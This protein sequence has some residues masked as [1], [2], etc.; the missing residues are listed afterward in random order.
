MTFLEIVLS[1]AGAIL[2]GL[3]FYY[4][5]RV[6]GPWGSLWTFLLVLVLAALAAEAWV[7]PSGPVFYNFSWIPTLFVIF[8]FGLILAA[9][10]PA[11]TRRRRENIEPGEEPSSAMALTGF[12]WILVIFL[13]FAFI[14]SYWWVP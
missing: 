1:I 3:L 10:T 2:I 11:D 12:F 9:A 6:T 5:F 7:T 13:L 8:L 4:V 14:S